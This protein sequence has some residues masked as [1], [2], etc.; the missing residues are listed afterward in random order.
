MTR[1]VLAAAAATTAAAAAAAAALRRRQQQNQI[2]NAHF[3]KSN[4]AR[5]DVEHGRDRGAGQAMKYLPK[6]RK[7]KKRAEGRERER[8]RERKGVR[9]NAG[10]K[11]M[12][13][14]GIFLHCKKR[15]KASARETEREEEREA[16]HCRFRGEPSAR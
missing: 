5:Q 11:K 10:S 8:P 2:S 4:T 9:D 3:A 15:A 7:M 6:Y 1:D 13:L 12:L 14:N 16:E